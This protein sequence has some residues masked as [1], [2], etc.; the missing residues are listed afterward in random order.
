M[1]GRTSRLGIVALFLIA[2]AAFTSMGQSNVAPLGIFPSPPE[3][4]ELEVRIW[5][6]QGAYQVG[7]PI[8]I[9]Y[10]VNEPAYIYIW[11]IYPDG[12][13]TPLFPNAQPGGAANFVQAGEHT[14]PPNNWV[15]GPPLGTEYLQ[16]LATKTPV[17]PFAYFS[18]QDPAAFQAQVEVQILGVLPV[19]EIS[20][21]FTSF[22]IFNEPPATFGT[23]VINSTPSGGLIYIDGEYAGYTPRTLYVTQDFHQISVT[24]PGYL[25]W[26]A[27]TLV[28][29]GITRT[30]NVTLVPLFPTNS[31]PIAN[32]SY[33]PTNPPVGAWGQFDASSS[34][35]SDGTIASYVWNFG[36]GSTDSGIGV[37][38]RFNSP[39]T[40]IVTLTVTDND[41]AS[42]TMTQAVQV[43]TSNQPP[44][45][46]FSA[47]P[48][49]PMV[50]AW[51]Q[52][53]AT[54]AAD[55][56]GTIASYVWNFGDGSTGTGSLV[57]H[58][59]TSSGTYIVTLMVT[60][61]DGATDSTSLA[62][63]VGPSNQSPVAGFTFSPTIPAVNAWVQFNG[64]ASFDPDGSI[65]NYA[66]DF[67]DG[68]SD[69]GGAVWHR[70]SAA[71][72]YVV[73]LT[74]TDNNGATDTNTQ[75][76][77][78]GGS[79]NTAPTASFSILPAAPTIGEWVRF[80]GTGSTDS[81]GSIASYHWSF[82]DGTSPVSGPIVYHQFASAGTYL[83]TL[84]VTDDDGA[85]DNFA[86][87][88]GMGAVQQAPVALF[89]F[90]PGAPVVGQSV[91]F[92]AS[93]SY[94]PDG[95]I[96][97]YAWDLDGNGV[98]DA[99]T[100]TVNATYNSAGVAMVRLTVLDNSGL[101]STS[102]QAV[103]ITATG[104][105]PGVPAMG[106]TPGVFVW[107]TDTWHLTVNAGAGWFAPHSYRLEVRSDGSFQ[108]IDQSSSGGVVPL[109]ILP[110]PTDEGR[111]LVFE[112]SLQAGSVDYE[113][114]VPASSS[115]WMKLELDLDGD[116]LVETSPGLVYL[117]HSMVHPPTS[118]FVV[119]LP[120]G[121]TEELTPSIN[122]RV[123]SAI[124]YTETS[125]FV[126]WTTTILNLEAP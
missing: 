41:G 108:S 49:N 2:F 55:T 27:A 116:G 14:V 10:S 21:D 123:G 37:W 80:D 1:K 93:T 43:G 98:D 124:A 58:Q 20:W 59:F 112:G 35:D 50:N 29:G 100:P 114:R 74:V 64:S 12:T 34:S 119:G 91:A 87:S 72:I 94:D 83:V 75:T 113:F 118:P 115:I 4:S 103:V 47:T 36:D 38:H 57:W 32:F 102:T 52:F 71:G 69:I 89:T 51:V 67:G 23:L 126:F 88:I 26:Q 77:Q 101:S 109:G 70:F 97:S 106:T 105:T 39:G 28:I 122:F 56:D 16:I 6:D 85:T 30:I 17:D 117:R 60:D 107:G 92:N 81:D 66:W 25:G 82:G 96:V 86:Q 48:T 73:T 13:A 111:T 24:K 33:S 54:A 44:N 84:T 45:A 31:A 63:Q 68:T 104:A 19:S 9:H 3:S 110:A 95:N 5:V 42:D 7:E 61:N 76:I 8:V 120:S 65:A 121:S 46:A 90:A 78:V 62:I 18:P 53:D 11:D 79:V 15:I 125:R 40:Y 22:E 99:F